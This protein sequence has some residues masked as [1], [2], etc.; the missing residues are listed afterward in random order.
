VLVVS[1]DNVIVREYLENQSVRK[2]KN[3]IGKH[4]IL[5]VDEA[6]YIREVALNLKPTTDHFSD[7]K[8]VASGSSSFNPAR[9]VG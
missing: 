3:F 6:R 8:V 2:L 7:V 1:G 4:S 9:D 5:L